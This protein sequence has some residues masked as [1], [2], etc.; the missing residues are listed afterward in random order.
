VLGGAY[1]NLVYA[2]A[3]SPSKA[4]SRL[5]FKHYPDIIKDDSKAPRTSRMELEQACVDVGL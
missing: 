1:V 5:D 2:L 4:S 3:N